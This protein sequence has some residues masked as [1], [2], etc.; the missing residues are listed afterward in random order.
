MPMLRIFVLL[1]II[2]FSFRPE[3]TAQAATAAASTQSGTI[4]SEGRF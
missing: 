1:A 3:A 2:L 4:D